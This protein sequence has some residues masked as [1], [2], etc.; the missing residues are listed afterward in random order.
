MKNLQ[1]DNKNVC[2]LTDEDEKIL[3][4]YMK[5]KKISNA[6]KEYIPIS[7]SD[8]DE[9]TE[10]VYNI[11]VMAFMDGI[12]FV[13]ENKNEMITLVLSHDESQKI[14]R[15]ILN[16]RPYVFTDM[17][18]RDGVDKWEEDLEVIFEEDTRGMCKECNNFIEECECDEYM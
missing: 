5:Y 12:K 4:N 10:K 13:K 1:V 3:S 14:G 9:L 8:S 17:R 6:T 16:C 2:L 11:A 18:F 7:E 15:H